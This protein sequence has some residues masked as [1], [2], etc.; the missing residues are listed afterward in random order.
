M[1][2][3]LEMIGT[4]RREIDVLRAAL[5]SK[6]TAP[7]PDDGGAEKAAAREREVAQL[8]AELTQTRDQLVDAR[9]EVDVL[10]SRVAE[11]NDI[12]ESLSAPQNN[13][14][15]LDRIAQLERDL[16]ER[17]ERIS[18][19]VESARPPAPAPAPVAPA[20]AGDDGVLKRRVRDLERDLQRAKDEFASLEREQDK[21]LGDLAQLEI[22]NTNFRERLR[23]LGDRV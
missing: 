22:D 2:Q 15:L 3:Y 11:R 7:A 10:Q 9:N 18:A 23:A 17:D 19:L 14:A 6:P 12:I 20:A 1:A 8:R 13:Q 5:G 21:L 16:F 4:Q